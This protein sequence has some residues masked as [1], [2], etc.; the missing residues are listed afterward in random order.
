MDAAGFR[1]LWGDFEPIGRSPEGG[2]LRYSWTE[3]DL[4]CRNW[5]RAQ[6]E[7]RNLEVETDRN[8]NLYAWWGDRHA[9]DAVLTGSHFDSVPHGGAYDGP[10]GIVSAFLAVDELRASGAKRRHPIGIVAFSEEEGGRFGVPCV[11]TRL[12]TGA[13]DADRARDLTDSDGVTLAEAMDSLNADPSVLGPDP[14]RL[15][16]IGVFVELHIEQGRALDAED[17][18]VGVATAIWPHGRWRFTFTG[19]ANHAGTTRLP[20]RS[21]PMLTAA[22]MILAARKEARLAGGVA[23]VGRIESDPGAANVIAGKVHAWLDA[24]APDEAV[25]NAILE[26]IESKVSERAGRDGTQVGSRAES[27]TPVVEFDAA[28][29]DRIAS[30]LGGV[31]VLPTGAGHDAGVV[32]AHVPTAMLF[33]RNRTGISHAPSETADDEDCAAGVDALAAVLRELAC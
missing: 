24:R 2:Y 30:L 5:F 29:R 1:E 13:L 23:T 15:R 31:P 7:K 16:Q 25:L 3:T 10:L 26:G 14:E 9:G 17:A 33:V 27:E 6:A 12:M 21:D 22:F 19:E 20:D 18:P 28:L 32:S 4:E 8:G 11:G